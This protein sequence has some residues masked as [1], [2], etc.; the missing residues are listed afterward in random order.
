[1]RTF[2]TNLASFTDQLGRSDGDLRKLIDDGAPA[3]N[4]FSDTINRIEPEVPMLLH[5]LSSTGQMLKVYLPGVEQ[6]LVLYPAVAAGLQS[7]LSSVGG[8]DAGTIHLAFRPDVGDPPNCYDGFLPRE[9]QRDFNDLVVR[10]EVPQ[11]LYC[12]VPHSDPRDVRGARNT[13]CLNAPG[14]RAASVE[15]CLGGEP[16]FVSSPILGGDSLLEKALGYDLQSGRVLAPDG[17]LYLLGGIGAG[18]QGKEPSSWQQLLL[19]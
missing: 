13:P 4:A 3:A 14:R 15:E 11:N 19:K 17:T 7:A 9:Q 1:V 18:Q 10:T 16:G 12:K 5:D 8:A 6:V 2:T